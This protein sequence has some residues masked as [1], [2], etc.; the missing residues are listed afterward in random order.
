MYQMH[1]LSDD[2]KVGE[3]F[4]LK[5]AASAVEAARSEAS[6][7]SGVDAASELPMAQAGAVVVVAVQARDE[8]GNKSDPAQSKQAFMVRAVGASEETV[9]FECARG[10]AAHFASQLTAAGMYR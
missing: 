9:E 3:A 2:S 4:E 7:H 1:L 6:F 10:D 8:F 5:V